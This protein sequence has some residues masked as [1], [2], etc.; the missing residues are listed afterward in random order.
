VFNTLAWQ[1]LLTNLSI[2]VNFR[3]VFNL[4]WVGIFV[5]AIIPGGWSGDLFKTY[6]LSRDPN[7][8]GGR[9]MSAIVLKNVLEL[10]IVLGASVLGLFLLALNYTLESG[11][12]ITIGATMT[13]LT[14]PLIVIIYLSIN[15]EATKKILRTL[16]R[17]YA[18]IRRRPANI[19][20]FETKIE[21]TVKEYHDGIMTLKTKPKTMVKPVAFQIAGWIFDL[22]ALFLIFVSIS[23]P[24]SVDKIIITNTIAVNFQTQG[25][26]L[27]GFA[28]L[29]SVNIYRILGIL[30][31][32]S[33]AS[34][35][36]AGFASFWFKMIISFLAFQFV[37]FSRC[38]P[39]F[40]MRLSGSRGKSGKDKK[41]LVQ[42]NSDK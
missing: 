4:S 20:D 35:M 1:R 8:D 37:V 12:L 6:L 34:A 14:L 23:Y 5:D 41:M 27:A 16:K 22:L 19:E 40:C 17:G 28:Q 21:S 24:V 32:V 36:L 2:K 38:V 39:P 7:I 10:L 18:F 31:N 42:S 25:V 26:A 30:P 29:I 9:S 11:V 13:L 3:T 15:L 33:A